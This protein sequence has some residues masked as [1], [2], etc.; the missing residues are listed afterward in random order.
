M[1]FSFNLRPNY[2]KSYISIISYIGVLPVSWYPTIR[3]FFKLYAI[4]LFY[5]FSKDIG[6]I[7]VWYNS[8]NGKFSMDVFPF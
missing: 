5:I 3:E 7:N 1:L 8:L 6:H 4:V 2:A